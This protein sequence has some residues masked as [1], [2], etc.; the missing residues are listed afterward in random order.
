M[1]PKI[2]YQTWDTRIFP[3][4]VQARFIK[5]RKNYAGYEYR[6]FLDQDMDDFVRT[7][8]PGKIWKCYRKLNLIVAKADF[9]RYLVL[10]KWGGVYLDMDSDML[11]PLDDLIHEDDD[12]IIAAETNPET[13][14]QWALMF[15][16]DHPLLKLVIDM[17]V[18]NIENNTYPND[19]HKMT[20]PSVFSAAL[21]TL[22]SSM[23]GAR[24]NH[25]SIQMGSD[26]TYDKNGIKYRIYGI[27]YNGHFSCKIPEC[28][29]LFKGRAKWH[30]LQ[31]SVP[32]I[33][34]N[35]SGD[36]D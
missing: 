32:L 24:V 6:F 3:T 25:S 22:H 4:D 34:D 28:F 1:I 15:K 10:Y 17:V 2:L 12:A 27:D 29:S 8:Y 18:N 7:H 9:W 33:N 11:L 35:M 23:Y 31:K 19:I 20:G 36:E 21:Q 14:V 16:A 13:F 30:H 26:V 5:M